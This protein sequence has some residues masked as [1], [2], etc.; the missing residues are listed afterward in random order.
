MA[1]GG[2]YEVQGIVLTVNLMGYPLYLYFV[3]LDTSERLREGQGSLKTREE[4]EI[5]EARRSH[6]NFKLR[7]YIIRFYYD[8]APA[9]NNRLCS[10]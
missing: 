1:N 6:V 5:K 4:V 10:S 3:Y 9:I 7:N 8:H 2:N